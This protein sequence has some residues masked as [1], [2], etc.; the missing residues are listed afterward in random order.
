M[1]HWT[2]TDDTFFRTVAHLFPADFVFGAGVLLASY[3]EEPADPVAP[4]P[5]AVPVARPRIVSPV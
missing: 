2:A 1:S 5:V 3:D 4:P